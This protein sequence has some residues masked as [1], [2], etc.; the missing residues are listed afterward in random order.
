MYLDTVVVNVLVLHLLNTQSNCNL[1]PFYHQKSCA[2]ISFNDLFF[3]VHDVSKGVLVEH[4]PLHSI[5]VSS[6][7]HLV[8]S[9]TPCVWS[10]LDTVLKLLPMA[11]KKRKKI[12]LT[13]VFF[14]PAFFSTS[15]IV[16]K[17]LKGTCALTC[18]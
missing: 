12:T 11:T 8:K 9:S 2:S 13:Q 14:F 5:F 1:H 6:L 4:M 18:Q 3:L 17:F 15:N 16:K 10:L 7:T